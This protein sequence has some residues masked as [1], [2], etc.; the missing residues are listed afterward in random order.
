MEKVPTLKEL[1]QHRKEDYVT[2][3]VVS[4][5]NDKDL[6]K[7]NI[8]DVPEKLLNLQIFAWDKRAGIYITIE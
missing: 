6:F 1:L 5:K 3:I 2:S 7:G 8:S 4:T